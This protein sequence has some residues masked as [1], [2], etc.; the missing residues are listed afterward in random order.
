MVSDNND[1]VKK[2]IKELK[3]MVKKLIDKK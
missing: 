1:D 3:V 2:E